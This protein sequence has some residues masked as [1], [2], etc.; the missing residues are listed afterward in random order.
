[1]SK[2]EDLC[3][4]HPC[5][6]KG[7]QKTGRIHL[8]VS[9]GCNIGCKFCDRKV[10][11]FEQRHGVTGQIITP[12]E[13]L[14][15]V[16]RA[17]EVG[18]NI[19][20]AGIAGPGDTLATPYALETF[21]LIKKEF[22]QLFL[23]MSTNGLLL[24][25]KADEIIRTDIDSLTVTVNAVDPVIG[26]LLNSFVIYKK[27]RYEGVEAA[28]ILIENQLTGIRKIAAA[29]ISVKVN[30]VL[31]PEININH[32]ETIAK[33]VKEAGASIYNIIPL[34]PQFELKEC[35]AP[36]CFQIDKSRSLAQKHIQVFRHCQHCRADAI[37]IPG[38]E[39]LS[40]Q[41]YVK[42]ITTS[43]TFSHG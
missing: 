10:N 29:G 31:V 43:E 13:A 42:K 23:C 33:T 1:M 21:R 24:P 15:V 11:D 39:D 4:K 40:R 32:I 16:R 14:E 35:S 28:K 5:Y 38:G 37:G 8:P 41:V 25:E 19:T 26:A 6:S 17:L 22:P 3:A 27:H 36:N 12:K 30:T 34:I 18:R 7:P 20:V 2:F 9:P